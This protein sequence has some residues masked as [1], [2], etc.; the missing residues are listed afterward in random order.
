MLC[1]HRKNVKTQAEAQA[2]ADEARE[3]VEQ[4]LRRYASVRALS[5]AFAARHGM[6]PK[7]AE[8]KFYRLLGRQVIVGGRNRTQI[9]RAP[10]RAL[11][12]K[13][14]IDELEVML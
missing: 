10:Q 13:D 12:D 2:D 5:Q 6:K 3:L 7:T 14:F 1:G 4:L 11:F 8:K 9:R